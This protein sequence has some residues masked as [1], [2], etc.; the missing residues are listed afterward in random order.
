MIIGFTGSRYG[1]TPEQRDWV[2][3]F[4]GQNAYETFH[5]GGC[6]GAD[7]QA[8]RMAKA[9]HMTIVVHPG[10]VSELMRGDCPDADQVLPATATLIRN[11]DIVEASD[12]IIA[13]PNTWREAMRGSGTWATI[14][15]AR[16]LE[17][18]RF[19]VFPNGR[20]GG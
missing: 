19:V 6:V 18:S 11:R 3:E 12:C 1:M 14:R 17:K 4:L 13:C 20:I 7:E 8:H 16:K 10:T 2:R 15:Y 9:A 5:H